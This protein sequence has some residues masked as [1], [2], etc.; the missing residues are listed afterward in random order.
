MDEETLMALFRLDIDQDYLFFLENINY[1]FP[2]AHGVAYLRD[3]IRMMFYKI[4]FNEEYNKI[5]LGK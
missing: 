5:I 1:M 4:N 3:A 2:K